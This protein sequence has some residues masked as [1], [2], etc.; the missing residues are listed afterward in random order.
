M[1]QQTVGLPVFNPFKVFGGHIGVAVGVQNK[2]E[3][4]A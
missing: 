2:G 3:Q 1:G 4:Q